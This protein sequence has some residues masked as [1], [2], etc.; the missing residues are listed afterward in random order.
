MGSINALPTCCGLPAQRHNPQKVYS[1]SQ[2]QNLLLLRTSRSGD[3]SERIF[4][5]RGLEA[6]ESSPIRSC[7]HLSFG[8]T[9]AA[10]AG[11]LRSPHFERRGEEHTHPSP[12]RIAKVESRDSL[13]DARGPRSQLCD[14]T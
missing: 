2:P 12:F 5:Q 1:P 11:E 3:G 4:P 9:R 8:K 7:E 14:V 10:G 13:K 6:S